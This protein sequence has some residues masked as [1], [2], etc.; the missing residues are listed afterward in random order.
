[1]NI[2]AWILFGAIAGWLASII[3]GRNQR[4]GCFAN[5]AVGIVGAFIGGAIFSA[6]GGSGIT[7]FNLWSLLVAVVGSVVLLGVLRLI[8]R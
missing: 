8:G 3:A 1:M 4:M 2:V 7:G 6:A 5:I